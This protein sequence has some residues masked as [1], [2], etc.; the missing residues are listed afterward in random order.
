MVGRKT[1]GASRPNGC[2]SEMTKY[3][4]RRAVSPCPAQR[5][6]AEFENC[7][8]KTKRKE[9]PPQTVIIASEGKSCALIRGCKQTRRGP[10]QVASAE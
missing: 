5:E 4:E 10:R 7:R 2:A 3:H 8:H 9:K 6:L 1:N